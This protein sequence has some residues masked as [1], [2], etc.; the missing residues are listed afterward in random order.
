MRSGFPAEV[1]V[2]TR[3][4]TEKSHS[5]ES[6]AAAL[7]KHLRRE[8]FRFG[9]SPEQVEKSLEKEMGVKRYK[10]YCRTAR[11]YHYGEHEID[12][13]YREMTT[14]TQISLLFSHQ[15]EVL[16]STGTWLTHQALQVKENG[17]SV[18]ELGCSSGTLLRFMKNCLQE[19]KLHGFD[20]I[21]SFIEI[22]RGLDDQ[23]TYSI[24]DYGRNECLHK[25]HFDILIS[26]LGIDFPRGIEKGEFGPFCER[27]FRNWRSAC[28]AGASL[29]VVLRIPAL[30]MLDILLTSAARSGFEF[31][32]GRSIRL[33]VNQAEVMPAIAFIAGNPSNPLKSSLIEK[34][35]AMSPTS[36][37]SSIPG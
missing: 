19:S 2:M 17:L 24:W 28:K 26:S 3:P 9:K 31:D 37:S 22:A 35:W 4:P 23:I 25:N 34:Y 20:R 11:K 14:L 36:L 10:E 33:Q 13:L 29:L 6:I 5:I 18:G 12:A 8:G 16:W 32:A 1:D 21:K 30:E 27:V 7:K 15:A